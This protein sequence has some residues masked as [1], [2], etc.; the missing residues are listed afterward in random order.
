MNP[1]KITLGE[2]LERWLKE[3]AW[4]NLAPRT[5]EGY[6]SIIRQHL[7]PK[8]GNISLTQLKPEHLQKY[9]SEMSRCGRCDSSCG[10]SAQTVI[11]HHTTLHKAL[12]TALEWGYYHEMPLMLLDHLMLNIQKCIPGMKR[13]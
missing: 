4:P 5:T 3:Y 8:L 7:I 13:K 9:Y 10:L 12:Q 2:F 11:H 6:D 1:G